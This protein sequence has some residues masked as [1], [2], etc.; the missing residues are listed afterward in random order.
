MSIGAEFI[1]EGTSFDM[2][3]NDSISKR[4]ENC[5]DIEEMI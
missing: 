3:T 4:K 5:W 2:I 1:D